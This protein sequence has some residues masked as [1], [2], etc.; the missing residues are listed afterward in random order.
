MVTFGNRN[1]EKEEQWIYISDMMA[2]L[3]MIFLFISIMYIKNI[4]DRYG[5]YEEK[6][7]EICEELQKEFKKNVKQWNM[8]ICKNG[9]LIKFDNDL[10]FDTGQWE[11]KNEFKEILNDFFPR[12]MNVIFKFQN[13]ISELRIE[14]HTDSRGKP[15]QNEFDSYLYNTKLSQKRSRHVLEYSLN[16]AEVRNNDRILEWAYSNITAHGLSSSKRIFVNGTEDLDASRRVEF[17]LRLTE[18]EHLIA[19]I[20]KELSVTNDEL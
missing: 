1:S 5:A 8:S 6:K 18:E 10:N 20:K 7:E 16:L 15:N 19:L 2:G 4:S 13:S 11:L 12:L 14:G 9:V 3:M 17:R